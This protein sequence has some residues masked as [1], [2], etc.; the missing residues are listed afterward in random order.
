[1]ISYLIDQK[2]TK[3]QLIVSYNFLVN[4]TYIFLVHQNHKKIIY[5]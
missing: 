1:M 4:L 3:L 2:Q 5:I